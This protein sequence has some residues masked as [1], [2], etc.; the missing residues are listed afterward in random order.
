MV[1]LDGP[2]TPELQQ[3]LAAV[4][5]AT[6]ADP[7]DRFE[8]VE[9]FLAALPDAGTDTRLAAPSSVSRLTRVAP[10]AERAAEP[11]KRHWWPAAAVCCLFLIAAAGI[12]TRLTVQ[13]QPAHATVPALVGTDR[14]SA[15]LVARSLDLRPRVVRAYSSIAPRGVVSAQKPRPGVSVQVGS[16]MTLVVSLGPR[17]VPV[18]NVNGLSQEAAVAR[19]RSEGFRVALTYSDTV[20]TPSGQVLSQSIAPNALRVPGTLVTLEISQKPWWWPF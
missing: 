10:L 11:G 4:D 14:A 18:A 9:A 16:S 5:R 17:P 20:F 3:I 13:A 6:A 12:F 8:S 1:S 15:V 19:L 7:D 2:M